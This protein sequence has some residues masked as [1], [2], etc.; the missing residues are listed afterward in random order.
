MGY[1][2]NLYWYQ[3]IK[4]VLSCLITFTLL[5][6]VLHAQENWGGGTDD[7]PVNFGFLFQYVP[8]EY[9]II[10][11]PN[12]QD[13]FYDVNGALVK[14]PLYSISSSAKTG[15]GLGFIANVKL[16][17]HFDLR[18]SPGYIFTEQ[19]LNYE[20]QDPSQNIQRDVPVSVLNFPLGIR[21]KSDRRK[22][23]R[24]YFVTGVRY[25]RSLISEGKI[26][27]DMDLPPAKKTVKDQRN[28]WWYEAGIGF[29]IYFDYFKLS[30]EIK[31][32]RTLHN[33]LRPE[34][35]PYSAPLEKLFIQNIPLSIYL[36]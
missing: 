29:Q 5:S 35:S 21:I 18:F 7:S 30:P 4:Y 1:L 9:I 25:S 6:P 8:S 14:P 36:E 13:P 2:F 31:F 3:M 26:N 24:A 33:V 16:T 11:K 28:M 20:Y 22:N 17:N 19:L 27:E 34:D 23:F 32:S 10:K 12:W 15:F